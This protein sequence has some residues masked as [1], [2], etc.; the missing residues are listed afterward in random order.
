[1][2]GWKLISVLISSIYKNLGVDNVLEENSDYV[3]KDD[4]LWH[5]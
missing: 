5:K 4:N 2:R 3:M 1:M